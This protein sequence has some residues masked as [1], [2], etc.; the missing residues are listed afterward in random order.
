MLPATL[1]RPLA[2]QRSFEV[3]LP[4]GRAGLNVSS[5]LNTTRIIQIE[6]DVHRARRIA[7]D[8]LPDQSG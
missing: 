3:K 4:E 2:V 8:R 7:L 6:V 5:R 1:T